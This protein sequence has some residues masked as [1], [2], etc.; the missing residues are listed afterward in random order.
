MSSSR[1]T[2]HQNERCV[3]RSDNCMGEMQ[4]CGDE[5]LRDATQYSTWI[6]GSILAGL[7]TFK[8]VSEVYD[9]PIPPHLPDL[10][11]LPGR[12]DALP[13]SP[14]HLKTRCGR[15]ESLGMAELLSRWVRAVP[16]DVPRRCGFPRTSTRK[17][18]ISST[19]R[20]SDARDNALRWGV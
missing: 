15:S 4:V 12:S 18:R 3:V 17:T 13:P 8:K 5:S 11:D 16:T 14:V 2:L 10:P 20:R 7:S 19:R 6:G 1:S 9:W